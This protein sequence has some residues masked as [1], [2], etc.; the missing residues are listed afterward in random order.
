MR[1]SMI[2]QFLLSLRVASSLQD[3]II[4]MPDDS[5]EEFIDAFSD[6]PTEQKSTQ[7]DD[8]NAENINHDTVQED[9][10]KTEVT[11]V[12]ESDKTTSYDAHVVKNSPR[13][14]VLVLIF[15][16]EILLP[17]DEDAKDVHAEPVNPLEEYIEAIQD[18]Y[19]NPN[20]GESRTLNFTD[21]PNLHS[22]DSKVTKNS[23]TL[24][25]KQE[26]ENKA[27]TVKKTNSTSEKSKLSANGPVIT[28]K[29]KVPKNGTASSTN[30]G[31]HLSSKKD[32]LDKKDRHA[33]QSSDQSQVLAVIPLDSENH[34]T[35]HGDKD[36]SNENDS[37]S[38]D[39]ELLEGG[40]GYIS[41]LEDSGEDHG[42]ADGWPS[43]SLFSDEN[44]FDFNV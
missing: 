16:E 19:T 31:T 15:G 43:D 22:K 33:S 42:D 25:A 17:V 14:K 29:D 44:L 10:G 38:D 24:P 18:F 6:S 8:V 41:S 34:D 21:V 23:S 1:S 36:Q 26:T 28:E 12:P 35:D 2:L 37:F 4:T 3:E 7:S 32:E 20:R 13:E 40:T 27:E 30:N 9:S 39:F 5:M 11:T